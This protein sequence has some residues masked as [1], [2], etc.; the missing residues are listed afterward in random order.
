MQR[1]VAGSP[2][3]R[4]ADVV[5]DVVHRDEAA[6]EMKDNN[7][8]LCAGGCPSDPWVEHGRIHIHFLACWELLACGSW[9]LRVPDS[10]TRNGR[11]SCI[12][13]HGY[14]FREA[15]PGWTWTPVVKTWHSSQAALSNSASSDPTRSLAVGRWPQSLSRTRNSPTGWLC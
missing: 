15:L 6:A 10:V 11:P 13:T 14:P 7:H 12:Q 8:C 1:Q 3:S 9:A 4:D 5:Q 2:G